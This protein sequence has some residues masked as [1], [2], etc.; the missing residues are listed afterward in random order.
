MKNEV[1]VFYSAHYFNQRMI[2]LENK[3]DKSTEN[4]RL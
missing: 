4:S 1:H 2:K 3:N